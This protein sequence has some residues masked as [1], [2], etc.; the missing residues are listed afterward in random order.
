MTDIQAWL[1]Q[2][3]TLAEQAT[4]GPWYPWDRGVGWLIALSDADGGEPRLPEGFRTDLGRGEDATFIADART[5]LP[6]ALG[7]LQ[8]ILNRHRNGGP[9][10]GYTK[11]G[12]DEIENACTECG[13]I[14]EY[15][16]AWPCPTVRAIQNAIGEPR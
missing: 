8:A 1:D 3:K 9:S 4:E 7:A 16:V 2:G 13:A 15:G 10:Q 12:Y 6:Q 14:G 11:G 5:R